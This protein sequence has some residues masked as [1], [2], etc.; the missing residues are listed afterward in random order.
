[1]AVSKIKAE[2][3]CPIET[4]WKIVTSLDNYSWRSDLSRITVAEDG[5]SFVEYTKDGHSTQFTITALEPFVC[6]EFDMENDNMKGHWTGLFSSVSGKT[7][8]EFTEDVKAKKV[9]MRPF[10]GLYLKKQQS[11][12][13]DDLKKDLAYHI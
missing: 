12:Y 3:N 5:K 7:S 4:V 11:R 2:F 10:V 9:F 8:I 13:L 6:Y 1:M